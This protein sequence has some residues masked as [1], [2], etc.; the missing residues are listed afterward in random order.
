MNRIDE[1][2]QE[3]ATLVGEMR[4]AID[5]AE[6]EKR[7][8]NA[9]ERQEQTRLEGAVGELDTRIHDLKK[10]RDLEREAAGLA[11]PTI[12]GRQG[13]DSDPETRDQGAAEYDKVF[14]LYL[15]HGLGELAPEQRKLLRTGYIADKR[16]QAKGAGASGGFTVPTSFDKRLREHQLQAGAM[17]Q[18]RAVILQTAGG[19]DIQIP[20][21]TAHGAAALV[22]EAGAVGTS[23]ETFGQV[24]MQA[25][26]YARL[27]KVSLELLEDTAIDLEGYLARELGRSIGALQNTHFVSG[28]AAAKPQ[29]V[30][31]AASVGKTGAGGQ[32]TT[33]I[34]DDLMDLFYSVSPPYRREGEWMANDGTIKAIRKL[35][36]ADN[37]YIWQPGLVGDE[38]DRL[39][40]R[41]FHSD[42]DVPVM[43]AN[44]RSLVFGDLSAY[45]IRDVHGIAVRRLD[46]RFADNL[47]VG[48]IAWMRS[49]GDLIDTTGAVKVYVNAAA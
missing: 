33:I 44:A 23:D 38:P 11:D 32:T 12:D 13:R 26:K 31:G 22:A 21:T 19:E 37:Q 15:R 36:D 30:V 48:F 8:L 7:G 45:M 49:D 4:A 14:D 43:A 20:K 25:F 6:G 41:P 29:G 35:K 39:L 10:T 24:T 34:T 18:T 17:R 3:R 16:D 9:E 28:D 40:G 2:L 5:K 46:E 27:V 47:Q 42:P 1:L